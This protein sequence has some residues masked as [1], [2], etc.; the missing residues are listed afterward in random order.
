M[1]GCNFVCTFKLLLGAWLRLGSVRLHTNDYF[2]L[3]ILVI[4]HNFLY[5]VIREIRLVMPVAVEY[6]KQH[7]HFRMF[8]RVIYI[9]RKFNERLDKILHIRITKRQ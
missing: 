1:H 6:I 3:F 7:F 4:I 5:Y 9:H 8:R 2:F